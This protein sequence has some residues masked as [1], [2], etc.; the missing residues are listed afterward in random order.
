MLFAI[1]IIGGL[2]KSALKVNMGKWLISQ[3]GKEGCKLAVYKRCQ[4][5]NSF[6]TS[7]QWILNEMRLY[8]HIDI[9]RKFQLTVTSWLCGKL[10][11]HTCW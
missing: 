10:V 6:F 7:K 8:F 4:C 1:C 5:K 2:Y 3:K 9:G 11:P